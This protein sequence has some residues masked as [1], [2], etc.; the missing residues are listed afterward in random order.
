MQ[1]L[2]LQVERL[3]NA[4]TL[5]HLATLPKRNKDHFIS[6][7]TQEQRLF[8]QQYL[9]EGQRVARSW[10]NSRQMS[11]PI[12]NPPASPKNDPE[13]Q[14]GFGTPVLRARLDLISTRIGRPDGPTGRDR[15]QIA[16][17]Q[18]G[19]NGNETQ[20]GRHANILDAAKQDFKLNSESQKKNAG[21]ADKRRLKEH[22]LPSDSDIELVERQLASPVSSLS[23]HA[24]R[25]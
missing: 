16:G 2:E 14:V 1:N 19:S 13:F 11:P 7:F 25:F 21:R 4:L 6:T 10:D 15:N 17:G 22:N 8:L 3:E 24:P 20:P 12:I 5:G 9:Y 18:E 23:T